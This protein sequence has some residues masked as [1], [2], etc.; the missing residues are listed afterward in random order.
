MYEELSFSWKKKLAD[1]TLLNDI[2]EL[3]IFNLDQTPLAF[4]A[5]PKTTMAPFGS[6]KVYLLYNY[7]EFM[8]AFSL[9]CLMLLS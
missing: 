1:L 4:L 2:P 9:C 7:F 3:L 6:H 5:A 8:T